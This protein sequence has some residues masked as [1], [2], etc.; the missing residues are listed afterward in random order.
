MNR[1]FYCILFITISSRALAQFEL[2]LFDKLTTQPIEGASVSQVWVNDKTQ[3]T[4]KHIAI[5]NK[6]GICQI[7]EEAIKQL[8]TFT[9]SHQSIGTVS[10]TTY[11]LISNNYKLYL[12][13]NTPQLEEAIISANRINE[14]AKD[15]SRHIE[16]INR[17]Q[18]SFANQQNTAD[19]LMN[20]SNVYIQKSQ[21]GGGS[22]ILR[23]FE[24]NRVLLVI[25]G[26]RLNNAIY[27]SGHLQNVIR[28]DQH[29]LEKVEVL[30][31]S[32][33]VIYGSDALG[34]V[35]SFFTRNPELNKSPK[36]FYLHN[37]FYNRYSSANNET[38]Y[39]YN[40]N[41]GL[42]K[43]ASLTSITHSNF[44]NV[45]QG[46]NRG[47]EWENVGL[48]PNFV[49]RINNQD[50]IINNPNQYEQT[51]SNY[52]QTDFSQ[53]I[54]FKPSEKQQQTINFQYSNT[55]NVP[56]YD[57]LTDISNGLPKS[58]QWFYGPE[59]RLLLSH[60]W[61]YNISRSWFDKLN[62][63]AAYQYIEESRN[64]R[65]FNN[66]WL[67]TRNEKVNV[68]SLNID[69]FKR[70]KTHEI[71]YG[72]DAQFNDVNSTALQTDINTQ[73]RKAL[74][75]RYP[76]GGNNMSMAGLFISHNW[77]INSHFIL[78][79][80]LRISYI[81]TNSN[82]GNS[83]SFYSFLP[84]T[85][86]QTNQALNGNIGLIYL[87]DAKIRFYVNV[88]NAFHAPNI[89]D[90]SKIFDSNSKNKMVIV[91]NNNLK[92]EQS[93]TSEIGANLTLIKR[94]KLNGNVYYTQLSNA[95]VLAQA[96]VNGADSIMYDD[97]MSKINMLIN[98]QEAFVLGWHV[99][100]N[101]TLNE[102]WN[103]YVAYTYTKGRVKQNEGFTPLDHIPP[104]YGRIGSQLQLKGFRLDA[105]AQYSGTKKLADYNLY[106]ED[107]LQYATS[108]GT[109]SWYTLN[110]KLQYSIF[111]QGVAIN[112]QSGVE[113]ILDTHYRLFAS[114]ISAM[115]RN[116]Y[117]AIKLGF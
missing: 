12:T 78:N 72:I 100:A 49:K 111:K 98:K 102:N 55:S 106:G 86:K 93:I 36:A 73:Q 23:G 64:D 30:Y 116:F 110:I 40:V 109:P 48:R 57:R 10:Y 96:K 97:E 99:D 38:T 91:P 45:I 112:L 51:E 6:K 26:V 19:L 41:I 7:E 25:D 29:L 95:F 89:D 94:F 5:T 8:A 54:L 9:I 15:I 60:N 22:P 20:Q 65:S 4:N 34:G 92:P 21:Q 69:V 76:A 88:S 24:A 80:G 3:F 33:S 66:A 114:G 79:D 108:T 28:I 74:N 77:E 56:R 87:H 53:K 83:L 90:L 18:L 17:Q 44:G 61:Q 50:V 85:V 11:Q 67:R 70:I 63:I 13:N 81:N 43:W 113:N 75:T 105:Y 14:K 84:P 115:G 39:N 103:L 46:K 68:F 47:A 117:L 2:Q 107:N 42:K 32:G 82:L 35:V 58:A 52:R 31:G 59:K 16:T 37:E 62:T 27:R 71:R 104:T 101:M 1:L